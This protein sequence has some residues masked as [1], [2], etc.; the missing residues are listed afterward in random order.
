MKTDRATW[1]VGTLAVAVAAL[2]ATAWP[3]AGAWAMGERA[4][5]TDG[6]LW[7]LWTAHLVHFSWSHL[8]WSG[9]VWLVAGGLMEREN[10]RAWLLVILVAAPA[11]TW[12][13]LAL[14]PELAR[15]GG[16]SGLATAPVVW[17]GLRWLSLDRG[18]RR[19]AGAV[20][21]AA[22]GWKIFYEWGGG[23]ALARFDHHAGD[24]RVAAWAHVAGA[25]GGVAVALP[26][27]IRVRV[28]RCASKTRE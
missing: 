28:A 1:P 14:E 26:G 23:A 8:A 18:V 16:L 4:S 22:V 6:E 27:V 12:M 9:L 10:R 19:V 24:V 5:L 7:R 21:L 20:V 13:T 2:V 25:L 17:A 11:V 3:A 15:Y